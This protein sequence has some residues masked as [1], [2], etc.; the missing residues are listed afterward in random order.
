MNNGGTK[1]TVWI[2]LTVVIP[3]KKERG[4]EGIVNLRITGI[5]LAGDGCHIARQD[6]V[7]SLPDKVLRGENGGGS[8]AT[9]LGMASVVKRPC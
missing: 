2:I 5:G 6:L 3:W 9:S 7:I 4:P 1:G 8:T